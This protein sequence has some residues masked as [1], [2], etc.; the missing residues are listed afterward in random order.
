MIDAAPVPSR[1]PGLLPREEKL[2]VSGPLPTTRF[3]RH[4]IL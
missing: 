3:A 4:M 1:I 2:I